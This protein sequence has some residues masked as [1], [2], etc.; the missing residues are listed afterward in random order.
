MAALTALRLDPRM[1]AFFR[2]L[3]GRGKP[4]KVAI[5][6][7]LRK[8]IAA[9]NAVLKTGEPARRTLPNRKCGPSLRHA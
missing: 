1:Q 5:T 7:I 4:A 8:L 2:R 6:A 3:K 9:L